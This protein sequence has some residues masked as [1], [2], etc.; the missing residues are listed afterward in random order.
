MTK[1]EAEAIARNIVEDN[2]NADWTWDGTRLWEETEGD[3]AI[4]I[5]ALVEAM[6]SSPQGAWP[7]GE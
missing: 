6:R 3:R 4:A 7:K 1:S 2:I 5:A